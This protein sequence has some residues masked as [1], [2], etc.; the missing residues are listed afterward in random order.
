MGVPARAWEG[1]VQRPRR[2]EDGWGQRGGRVFF[3][4][5][6]EAPGAWLALCSAAESGLRAPRL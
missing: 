5:G 3:R 2:G 6:G 1:S 4:L